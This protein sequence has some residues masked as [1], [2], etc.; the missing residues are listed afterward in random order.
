MKYI[1][2]PS[3]LAADFTRLGEQ[4]KETEEAG[5][6][7]LHIDVMDGIFVPSISFGM[8][9]IESIR[10]ISRQFFD[11]HLM[12]VEPERYIKAFADCGADGITFHLEAAKEPGKV[13]DK[14]H[15]CGK[16]AGISIKPGTPLEALYPYVDRVEMVLLMSVEPG[17]GGQPFLP[18]AYERIRKLRSFLNEK[19][20]PVR[21]EVDGGVGKKNIREVIQAGADIFVAGSGVF[22]KNSIT[23]NVNKFLEAFREKGGAPLWKN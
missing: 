21:I 9:L 2:A 11:V 23:D 20:L 18:E 15:E 16:K 6:E 10:P 3:L 17:F 8:P 12:I 7:Y 13:I 5:A 14:I 22:K 1:L 19:N 4:I